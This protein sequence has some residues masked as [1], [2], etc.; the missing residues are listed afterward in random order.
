MMSYLER[1]ISKV[2]GTGPLARPR[3]RARFEDANAM[4]PETVTPTV[5]Q[6]HREQSVFTGV[7]P[8]FSPSQSISADGLPV[9]P[10]A[11]HT[12][13]GYH[14]PAQ[15]GPV[16][17]EKLFQPSSGKHD[18]I[19]NNEQRPEKKG[20]RTGL[21]EQ[22]AEIAVKNTGSGIGTAQ[23]S[24]KRQA[25]HLSG[26]AKTGGKSRQQA[27]SASVPPVKSPLH[28]LDETQVLQE[29]HPEEKGPDH[30]IIVFLEQDV[31]LRPDTAMSHGV[32]NQYM[33][34]QDMSNKGRA[35]PLQ[36]NHAGQGAPDMN[37]SV[38]IGRVIVESPQP[39]QAFRR[40]ALRKPGMS[41]SDYLE[42]RSG[43]NR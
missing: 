13:H 16:F 33:S 9:R 20:H 41:L 37:I 23:N 14:A 12:E 36:E 26:P 31:E 30:G 10:V 18:F 7:D 5:P 38:E 2:N 11:Q 6:S 1:Q 22:T 40:P 39:Q 24:S 27:I 8:G 34:N 29:P 21:K 25:N 3:P 35:V 32:S 4:K 15:N 42:K 43:G 17:I 19:Q 28:R